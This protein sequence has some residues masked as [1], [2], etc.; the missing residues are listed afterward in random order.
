VLLS[1]IDWRGILTLASTFTGLKNVEAF[2]SDLRIALNEKSVARLNPA[3]N[4]QY[5][6]RVPT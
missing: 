5:K 4:G 6:V 3:P 2:M 1:A